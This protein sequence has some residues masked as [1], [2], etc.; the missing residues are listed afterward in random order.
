ML[1]P[2]VLVFLMFIVIA[3][4]IQ[5]KALAAL[6]TEDKAKVVDVATRTS[7]GWFLAAIGFLVA[8]FVTIRMWP[9]RTEIASTAALVAVLALG[10]A[11][12]VSTYRRYQIAGMPKDFLK[13]FILART[14]RTAGAIS[15]F[16][17]VLSTVF[18]SGR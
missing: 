6:S 8:F 12:G 13:K 4:Q 17:A 1:I 18:H 14:I 16:A 10:V 5:R 3:A 2:A 15:L 11:G 7:L 9:E